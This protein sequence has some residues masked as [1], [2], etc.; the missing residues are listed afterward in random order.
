LE[1]SYAPL[2]SSAED[3]VNISG[4]VTD[5]ILKGTVKFFHR[6]DMAT[7]PKD[8]SVTLLDTRS[9]KEFEEGH[10]N[11]FINIPLDDLRMRYV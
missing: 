4:M 10:I 9:P 11:G 8:I 2:F 6:H 5:N 7:L 3:P 1:L